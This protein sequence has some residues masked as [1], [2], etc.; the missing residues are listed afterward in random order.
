[1]TLDAYRLALAG[2]GAL[3]MKALAL[4]AEGTFESR[5]E[6][7]VIL[8]EVAR[9]E[10]RAVRALGHPPDDV[11][12]ASAVERCWCLLEGLDL[13]G[14]ANAYGEVLEASKKLPAHQAAAMRARLEPKFEEMRARYGSAIERLSSTRR[15]RSER[16]LQVPPPRD[17]ELEGILR[18]FPGTA[19]LWF[20]RSINATQARDAWSHVRKAARLE[21]DDSRFVAGSLRLASD[22]L[23]GSELDE[24]L[25]ST[26]ATILPEK[27][28][29]DVWLFLALAYVVR[30]QSERAGVRRTA[31]LRRALDACIEGASRSGSLAA[32][33][34]GLHQTLLAVRLAVNA[35]LEGRRPD[36]AV[37]YEAGLG[38]LAV[39]TPRNHPTDVIAALRRKA[40]EL[41]A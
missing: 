14:A 17:D 31:S 21:P 7:A 20:W 18:E 8:H 4:L 30:A 36:E 40:S 9:A 15:A 12:L 26:R 3:K 6:A 13:P 23:S 32:I 16:S 22:V 5:F 37:L 11:K 39:V 29:G 25:E 35:M 1:M 27:A 38:E 19:S 24:F 33:E 34:P 41:A 10:Q 28:T 2:T